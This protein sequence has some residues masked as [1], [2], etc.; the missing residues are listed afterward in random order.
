M[1]VRP[2]SPAWRIVDGL[3]LLLFAFSVVVQVNDPDPLRWIAIYSVAGLA[4]LMAEHL[5]W[6]VFSAIGIVALAWATTLAPNI[7]GRVPFLEMFQE[8]EMKSAAVEESREMYGLLLI[9]GWMTVLAVRAFSRS[10]R[11]RGA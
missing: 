10:R 5:H 1:V 7:I 2:T 9:A 11:A 6:F 4:C 8:F 3:F